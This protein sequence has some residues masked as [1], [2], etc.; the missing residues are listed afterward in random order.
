[1]LKV[2]SISVEY[3]RIPITGSNDLAAFPV[4][5][6]VLPEGQDPGSGDWLTAEWSPLGEAMI[7]VGPGTSLPLTRGVTYQIWVRITAEPEIP[8]LAPGQVHAT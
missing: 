6:A 4:E 5:M 7:L 8:V 2:P 3:L 1:M